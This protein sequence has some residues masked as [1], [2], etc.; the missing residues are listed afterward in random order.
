MGGARTDWAKS[1]CVGGDAA[2]MAG[3]LGRGF[4]GVACNEEPASLARREYY[5]NKKRKKAEKILGTPG[6][7]GAVLREGT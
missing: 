6:F 5:S 2:D 7:P 3:G 4:R 1:D